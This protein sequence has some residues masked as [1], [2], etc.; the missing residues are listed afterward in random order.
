[1]IRC[2][3]LDWFEVY[4]LE[5]SQN[6]PHDAQFFRDHGEIV[7]ERP[8]GTRV[9]REMFTLLDHDGLPWIEIRRLP[10]GAFKT[11]ETCVLEPYSCHIRLANRTC[12]FNN[13]IE[14]LQNFLDKYGYSFQRISRVDLCLDFEYFDSGDNPQDFI[15]RY[16]KGKYA[17]IN[18]SNLRANGK[19]QWDGVRWNSLSWGSPTSFVTTKL[20]NKTMELKEVK[21]KPYIRQSWFAAGLIDNFMTMTKTRED[22]TIYTPT[23]WRL[24]FTLKS[25]VRGWVQL[26]NNQQ[27]KN[28]YVSI[29][30]NLER[31]K[32]RESMMQ[33][34]ASV[35]HH[36]FFFRY[37]ENGKT[38]YECKEK[39]LFDFNK[40]CQEY[41]SIEKP[42]TSRPAD[43]SLTALERRLGTYRSTHFDADIRKAV[44]SIL[45]AIRSERA[46]KN[47]AS[48][49]DDNERKL[50]QRLLAWR[51]REA[52]S[53]PLE[54]TLKELQ[55][56]MNLGDEIF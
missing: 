13:A 24:E 19:D 50:L 16:L 42:M 3:N 41:L 30:N 51:I 45:N 23:I 52:Q 34:F 7:D 40:E 1:M 49:H 47:Y 46:A 20:Y 9:Y 26:E 32:T 48:P 55:A 29:K 2:L 15:N 27:G 21:D 38:K 39:K 43:D 4:V 25:A 10:V 37:F 8:Y 18:Q 28:K 12:Y 36:Y 11:G 17:K 33:V 22:G 6:Y 31:Y 54:Q 14:Q 44:D 5:D 53:S 35:Q 56:L